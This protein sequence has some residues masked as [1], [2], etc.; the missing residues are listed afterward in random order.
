MFT[1]EGIPMKHRISFVWI[2]LLAAGLLPRPAIAAFHLME[3]EQLIG[4]VQ[5][6]ATAQAIQIRQRFAGQNILAGTARLVVRDAAGLNPITL[7][8][9]GSNPAN[10]AACARILVATPSFLA[11]TTPATVADFTIANIPPSYL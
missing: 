1:E 11:K 9:F 10:A 3:V 6:D 7:T 8:N 5:G 2:I 4:G